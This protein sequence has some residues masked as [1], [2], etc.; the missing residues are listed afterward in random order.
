MLLKQCGWGGGEV[1]G[2]ANYASINTRKINTKKKTQFDLKFCK[3]NNNN[4]IP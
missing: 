2:S 4:K 3:N 1:T